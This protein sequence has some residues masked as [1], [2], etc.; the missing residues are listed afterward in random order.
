M[1][2]CLVSPFVGAVTCIFI[3]AISS[4]LCNVIAIHLS[5]FSV[6]ANAFSNDRDGSIAASS[7]QRYIMQKLSLGSESE[8]RLLPFAVLL[9][10]F[11]PFA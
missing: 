10:Y 6:A 4:F 2:V 9:G 11:F 1:I 7:I 5:V 3:V 8:V